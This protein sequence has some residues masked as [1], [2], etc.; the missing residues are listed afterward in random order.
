MRSL[1]IVSR[2]AGA[3]PGCGPWALEERVVH[4]LQTLIE[5]REQSH[6]LRNL[7]GGGEL[8]DELIEVLG[9]LHAVA[10]SGDDWAHIMRPGIA[11]S[12]SAQ[13]QHLLITSFAPQSNFAHQEA[14][15]LEFE[16]HAAR[17]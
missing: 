4:L 8:L 11:Q 5:F 7:P 16:R 2:L 15:A 13:V 17:A 3:I 10:P 6:D 14:Q 1:V 12:N 9:L